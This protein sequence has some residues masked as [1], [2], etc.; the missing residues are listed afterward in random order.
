MSSA[1]SWF[2]FTL[3]LSLL[4]HFD[5]VG[6][7]PQPAEGEPRATLITSLPTIDLGIHAAMQSRDY[8]EAVKRIETAIGKDDCTAPD[9]LRY[10]QG[11]ALTESKLYDA[12]TAAFAQLETDYPDSEWISR[13]RFGRAHV[14]VMLRQYSDAGK[15]YEREAERLLSRGRKD[16]LA[17]IYL[18]F[19]ER[20]FVGLPADDPSKTV[21]PDYAQSLVFYTEAVKLGPTIGLRQQIEFRIARCQEELQQHDE[22]IA[23]YQRFL[24]QYAGQT[25]KSS[26]AASPSVQAEARYR[27]G[28]VQLTAGRP[29]Q[30]RKTWQDFLSQADQKHADDAAADDNGNEKIE[31]LRSRAEYRLAHTY[32]LPQP[33]SIGDLELAVGLAEKFVAKHPQH[34][35]APQAELE[36]AQGYSRHGR[37]LQAVQRLQKLI[38]NPL[39]KNSEQLPAVR[40]MLGQELLAQGKYDEA[41]A[42]WKQFLDQHPTDSRW[43]EVQKRIVDTEYAK[44][45]NALAEKRYEAARTQWQTFLNKYPL[46]ARA[47]GILFA[48]GKMKYTE[49]KQLQDQRVA[50]A[51]EQGESPQ[52]VSL[53]DASVQLFEEAIVDWRRVVNKYPQHVEA[54]KA[55]YMIGV[56]LEDQLGELKQALEAYKQVNGAFQSQAQQRTAR[57]TSPELQLV[58]ERKFRSDEVPRIKLTTRNL[59]TVTVKVYRVDMADYFRKMHLARGVESL[60]I[61]LIDPDQQFEHKIGDFQKYKQLDG[62]IELDMEGPGVVAVTVSSEKLEATTM[63]VVSDVDMIVKS[64]RNELF[65]FAENMRTGKPV[66]GVSV[67]V[68][69]G[70]KVFAETTTGADGI[71]QQSYDEL[72]TVSDLRVF[73]I[74]EGHMASTVNNLDGLDFAVGLT[75]RGFL[76]TDRPVYR[77]GQLVNIKGIVRW[78]KQDRFTFQPGE[79]FQLDVYDAGG[80][81]LQSREVVL[82]GYG[83][84][85][86]NIILPDSAPQGDYRVHLHRA[87]AGESDKT[88]T[89]SFETQFKVHEYKLEPV[90][91]AIDLDKAVA[92]RG[93]KVRATVSLKYY[94]GTPLSNETIHYRFGPDGEQMTGKTDDQGNLAVEFET[95]RFS[96]SQPLQLVVEYRERALSA[97]ETVFLATRGFAVTASTVRD[98]YINGES[99]E[100]LF[101]VAGPAGD[102]VATELTIEVFRQTQVR[103]QTTEKRVQTHQVKTD[104]KLGEAR[105]TL[106]LDEGGIYLIRATGV[107]RFGNDVSGEHSLRISGDK[108]STRLR[109]LADRHSFDVGEQAEINLHWREQP[110]LALVT[111]EGASVLGYRLVEL[112]AGDNPLQLPMESDFAPN[113]FV[114]VAVM[115]RNQF[116]IASSEFRVAQELQITLKPDAKELKPGEEV[117]VEVVVTDPQG[118]PLETELSLSLVQANLLNLFADAHGTVNEFFSSG[119]RRRSVRESTSCTFSYRPDTQGVSQFL[120]NEAERLAIIE[121]EVRALDELGESIAMGMNVPADPFAATFDLPSQSID[122]NAIEQIESFNMQQA[123][124]LSQQIQI[125]PNVRFR[126]ETRDGRQIQVPNANRENAAIYFDELS[127]EQIIQAQQNYNV[128]GTW[129]RRYA[130]RF[131]YDITVN[132]LTSTGKFL[133]VNGRAPRDIEQLARDEGLQILPSMAYSETAFWDPTIVTDA[134]GKASV[135]ITL[136]TRSTAWRLQA[137]GINAQT[138]AGQASTE[139]ITKK[140]LF[141]ELKLPLAFTEGDQVE[142]PVE[143]HNALEGPHT[144]KVVMKVTQG[145][146]STE[147]TQSFDITGPGI[148]PLS[149]PVEIEDAE[150]AVFELTTSADAAPIDV[151]SQIVAIRPYGFP[152]YQTASGTSSQ[153]TV[154]LLSFDKNTPAAGASMEIVIGASV[155][156]ALLDSVLGDDSLPLLR[157]GLPTARPLERSISDTLGGIALLQMI[158]GARNSDAPQ[159]QAVAGRISVAVTQMIASQNQHGGWAWSGAPQTDSS[160]PYLSSRIMWALSQARSAGFA[161]SQEAFDKGKAYLQTAF[162]AADQSDLEQQTILLHG[163]A[164]CGCGDF[165]FANRLYRE[166]N[167]LSPAALTHLALTLAKMNRPEMA[168]TL[169]PLIKIP[170]DEA[171]LTASQRAGTLPWMR[172]RTELQAMFLLTLQ[173]VEPNHP[174]VA[175]L[176]KSL[177][178]QRVGSRWPVEKSNGPVIAALAYWHSRTRQPLEKYTL[179]VSVNNHTLKT[180]TIDPAREGSHRIEVDNEILHG[181]QPQRLEF[182]LDGRATFSYSAVLTGFVDADKIAAT[183]NDWTVQR[184]YE[185]AQKLFAGRPVP[186]GFGVVDGSYTSFTNPLT[187]LPVGNRGE[188]TLF[189]RRRNVNSRSNERYDYLVLTEPIPAGCTVLADS[190]HGAFER[191]EIEPGQITFYIGDR[192]YPGD[193]RYTLVGYVPGQYRVPQS[194]LR[195]F[196]EP[197]RFTVSGLAALTV[198]DADGQSSD[199]YKWTPD[200]HYYLGQQQHERKNYDAAHDHLT[201]LFENWR[202]DADKYKNVVQWLFS[203]SLAKNHHGDT[204]RYFEILKEKFPDVELSFE[205][206]LRVAKSYQELGEYERSYLVYRATVEASFERESQVAGFLNARGEFVRSVQALEGLLRDYPAEA[207]VATATYA[208]AQE[209]YRRAPL[210]AEDEK[211]KAAELTRVHLIDAAITMLDHFVTTWPADPADDQASFALATALIDLEQYEQAIDRCEAYAQRYPNSRLLD[212]YWYIIGYSHFE[213]EHPEEALQMCRKVAEA[214]FPV[215]ETGGTRAADNRWEAIYIMGQIYHSL[216]QAARAI[217][218]YAKVEQRFADASEAIKFF[219][220]K[221][222]A[223]P[224]VTTIEPDAAK[225]VELEFRNLSEAAIK[226]YRIDLMKFGLMQRNLDRITA[227]NLAGIQPYHEEVVSLGDGNDFRDRTKPLTLPLNEEGAYLIVCRGENLYA[228]GLALVSPLKLLVQEDATSGRVRVSVKDATEDSFVSDVHVKVIGSA[229][230]KFVSE[231]TDLRGLAIA[232]DIRGTSTVI[233]MHD[234]NRY[235]FYRGQTVLQEVQTEPNAPEAGQQAAEQP[236]KPSK[237]KGA[238]RDNLFNQNSIFQMEQ[239]SNWDS[240]LNNSRTGVQSKEAY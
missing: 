210:A 81:R 104:A 106:T 57:L 60:D 119:Q 65:V 216:G 96:E 89:L 62:D 147:Q 220:R 77:S 239:N 188:V 184:R 18:E 178:S 158:G 203:T 234:S 217:S 223:L 121:R 13:A 208:L 174:A 127:S 112:Q 163:M 85:N 5:A 26:V 78:V 240:L 74:H 161:V 136:P 20:Y 164:V 197:D 7:E 153:S 59:E 99:F 95:Q 115:Q 193:I 135:T 56:T 3:A 218:E 233:A 145:D 28:A 139:L 27:L 205:N 2:V 196:Y 79:T 228:S 138:L 144:I 152:V 45:A 200:E 87:S 40:Q 41:I 55:A 160:D 189:P 142:V 67:L 124:Q 114:S 186:R 58:T 165:A 108:D 175:A 49:A 140:D 86:S 54:S 17:K 168:K 47:P 117:T 51:V 128:L 213:L 143:I 82:N 195:S 134:K 75:P 34:K 48:F 37:H 125:I 64:S 44:A 180:L 214:A 76:Y 229:N 11:V 141:G 238:L 133:A 32:G 130:G 122:R 209:T 182:K 171:S 167:R 8:G 105:Q 42:A 113:L 111:F 191:Y 52:T 176:A 101:K 231:N 43:P 14:N 199:A 90:E 16:E 194:I 126:T 10:L 68:S 24:K 31:K 102:A 198:L 185:P 4:L 212:S 38:D 173:A 192:R 215:S 33:N 53:D 19:A 221:A 149:F 181:D 61:A 25:P 154:A 150:E 97:S 187:Q 22:A 169:I 72:K 69:D 39:Y 29:Q 225:Q 236:G 232:D 92:F 83:T 6:Q 118:R 109:I 162:A 88:G 91:I 157:C 30:A 9:Y 94:Y 172:N 230:D 107:D 123:G 103:G 206:I 222:I 166:R 170:T 155:N 219:N 202:L 183:T 201:T 190:V 70:E 120:R 71:L 23:S 211:L 84:I 204:V 36:I 148:H 73:A 80:R 227:I 226:V 235:A 93:E 137:K 237:G 98:V 46:D 21:Q 224:E 146:K 132:G 156:R 63:V 66:E 159:R 50:A 131:G 207:Y 116:H 1:R 177:M 35:L 110:A 100:T 129:E 179:V 151:A 15:I 12:A